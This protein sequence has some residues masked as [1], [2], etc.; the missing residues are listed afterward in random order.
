MYKRRIADRQTLIA[1]GL[2]SF[3][4][5]CTTATVWAQEPAPDPAQPEP[6]WSG[7]AG[8]GLSITGGNTDTTNINLSFD[9]VRD[10]K[11]RNVLR[12]FGLYLRGDQADEVITD[13][14]R[15]GVRDE[16]T[17]NERTFLFGE[18]SYLRDP[19]KQIDYLINPIGGLGFKVYDTDQVSFVVDGG[20]GVV[21]EKNPGFERD[22]SG[23]L[24]AGQSFAYRFSDTA[25]FTQNLTALWKMNNFEDALYH[26]GI[27][28]STSII[29][30]LEL[31]VEYI[32][33]FKNVTP[34]P[35]VKKTDTAFLTSILYK[36]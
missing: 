17:L 34:S 24:N 5:F 28:L 11:Q 13:R 23:T 19:F 31:K 12:F 15:L 29:R 26:F 16:Y 25:Q 7:T 35:D 8:G 4:W 10:P 36:F 32:V 27:A 21:W 30:I 6:V 33:D 18:F 1:L 9:I 3:F 22:T 14:L 20:A 2:T